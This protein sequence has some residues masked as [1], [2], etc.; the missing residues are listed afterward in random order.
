MA[1]RW[2]S[3]P[4]TRWKGEWH[5]NTLLSYLRMEIAQLPDDTTPPL[6]FAHLHKKSVFFLNFNMY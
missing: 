3:K 6:P 2:V 4:M 1:L 5:F